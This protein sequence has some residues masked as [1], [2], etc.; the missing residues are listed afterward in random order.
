MLCWSSDSSEL[1]YGIANGGPAISVGSH[2]LL[3]HLAIFTR[4][5]QLNCFGGLRRMSFAGS[6][7]LGL[8]PVVRLEDQLMEGF[9]GCH[10]HQ[11]PVHGREQHPLDRAILALQ[12]RPR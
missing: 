6:A 7:V 10:T 4:S 1:L 11:H 5:L 2:A 9:P 8:F 12:Q 3:K